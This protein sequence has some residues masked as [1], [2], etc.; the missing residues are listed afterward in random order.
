MLFYYFILFFFFF[1]LNI[2]RAVSVRLKPI[3]FTY[4]DRLRTQ[5][6]KWDTLKYELVP[7]DVHLV[8]SYSHKLYNNFGGMK[9]SFMIMM[10]KY[11]TIVKNYSPSRDKL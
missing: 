11:I 2:S 7:V 3:I 4:L 8:V 6:N 9:Y 1:T 10:M 5:C